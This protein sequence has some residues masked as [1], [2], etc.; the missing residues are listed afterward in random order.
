MR[1]NHTFA[2]RTYSDAVLDAVCGPQHRPDAL[3][4]PNCRQGMANEKIE[5]EEICNMTKAPTVYKPSVAIK[6][7]PDFYDLIDAP[8]WEGPVITVEKPPP[9]ASTEDAHRHTET[10]ALPE[11][12]NTVGIA[13]IH[14]DT[15]MNSLSPSLPFPFSCQ[16]TP[17][18]LPF[19][20]PSP[21]LLL[22][23]FLLPTFLLPPALPLSHL[24]SFPVSSRYS[25]AMP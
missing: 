21:S 17:Y 24:L 25:V 7:E 18:P 5:N 8:P 6:K 9:S 19:R 15:Y 4:D 2:H 1:C 12:Q 10:A 16:L 13:H 22:P 11:K 3:S 14:K 20:L 23:P